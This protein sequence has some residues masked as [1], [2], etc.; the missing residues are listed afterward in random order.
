MSGEDDDE[1][2]R[3]TASSYMADVVNGQEPWLNASSLC[4]FPEPFMKPKTKKGK[5]AIKEVSLGR[6]AND[7]AGIYRNDLYGD[8]AIAENNDSLQ[9]QYGYVIF[10]LIRRDSKSYRFYMI[11]TGT[12]AHAF[13][14]RSLEFKASDP[15]KP[16]SIDIASLPHFEDSDFIRQPHLTVG[17]FVSTLRIQRQ[18]YVK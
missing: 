2:F 18:I 10:D 3:I 5:R 16:N 8:I 14:R 12:A 15:E 11:S 13:K 1:L 4:T 17:M 6:P 9:L 7:F